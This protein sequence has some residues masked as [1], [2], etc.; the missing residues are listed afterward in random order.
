MKGILLSICILLTLQMSSQE[1]IIKGVVTSEGEPVIGANV[2]NKTKDI[3]TATDENGFFEINGSPNDEISISYLGFFTKTFNIIEG[4][5]IYKLELESGNYYDLDAV[6]VTALG[7]ERESRSLGYAVQELKS[8]DLSM[9]KSLNFIDNLNGKLAGVNITHGATGVGSTSLISIRGEASFTNNNPLFIVDGIPVNN[10]TILNNTN[11][12]AS[13]FQEVD[14]GNGMMDINPEEIASLS[15]LK[16]PAAAALYGTRASNGVIV[17]TTKDG[18]TSQGLGISL[19][20]TVLMETPFQLPQFQN[21]YGQGNN[22]QF[23]FVDGRGGGINDVI[24]YSYGPKLNDGNNIPQFDSPV[25]L[26]NGQVVRGAD[27]AIHGGL[28]ITPTPFIAH[29]DNLKNFYETGATFMNNI[30]LSNSFNKGSFRVAFGDTR[31]NSILPGVNLNR[32]NASFRMKFQPTEKLTFHSSFNYIYTNSANRPASGYGSENINYTLVAWMGRQTNTASLRDYWQPGLEGIQQFSFNYTYFDNPYFILLENTNSLDRNRFFGSINGRYQLNDQWSLIL[33]TGA[34]NQDEL[35]KF[36]R[37]YSSNRF[38]NGAYAEQNIGFREWNTDVLIN[39][40]RKFNNLTLD[41]SAGGNRMDQFGLAKYEQV[42]ALAQ[43]GIFRFSNG[44]VPIEVND[45]TARKRIN[46]VYAFAKLGFKDIV[47]LDIT[48]RN[49]WSS[50][51]AA[52]GTTQN[53]SFFYPSIASSFVLTNLFELPEIVS[54]AKLRANYA[55]VGNDTNPYGT[56]GAYRA[57]TP[58]YGQPT[59]TDQSTIANSNLLPERS[60]ANELGFDVRFV[61]DRLGIDFTY[62]SGK[63][64]NQILSLPIAASTGYNQRVLNGG[65]VSNKGIELLLKTRAIADRDLT[66][67]VFANFSRNVARVVALPEEANTITLA[68]SRVYD[69]PNQ[70]VYFLVSEGD[71]IGDMWGTGYLKNENGDFII[72]ED[73]KYIVDNTLKKLGNYNPDFILGLTNEIRFKNIS[74]GFVFDWRQGGELVSRTQAL[75]GVAGQLKETGYRP[76]EGIIAIGVRADGSVNSTPIPAE[77]YYRQYYDRNHEE[78]N[79]YDASY[80]KLRQF[81]LGFDL[82]KLLGIEKASISL[83]GRN[84]FAFSKIPHFDPEQLAVQGNQ[85]IRGVEDMSYASTRS[86]GVSLNLNF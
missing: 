29:P 86:L 69:N 5:E 70:T 4:E 3:G 7:L 22:G 82:T 33:R 42:T 40:I 28:P 71:R 64:K 37:N 12:L 46:S 61:E 17:I 9:V 65:E 35:R 45:F 30:A 68:Y 85:F 10:N 62:Y 19:N 11:E 32:T 13:G 6:V 55:E 57:Y 74:L 72:G 50:A 43:Q 8:E 79:T 14:F 18:S 83:I 59:F 48:G 51:L 20:S 56:T 76:D 49:D 25:S 1:N 44:A 60:I 47:Y 73:G 54:F 77:T 58:V 67:D 38:A 52:P 84:L 2:Y 15:V 24:T 23:T 31:S 80:L 34:D 63:N 66:W 36:K 16:G 39:Y 53:T 78:N 27:V 41:F 81:S 21:E 26:P 75:A